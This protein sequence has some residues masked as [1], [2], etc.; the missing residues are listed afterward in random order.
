MFAHPQSKI[1]L[2]LHAVASVSHSAVNPLTESLVTSGASRGEEGEHDRNRRTRT[3]TDRWYCRPRRARVA[4]SLYHAR[5]LRG[6]VW[7]RNDSYPRGIAPSVPAKNVPNAR[8]DYFQVP[9]VRNG[10]QGRSRRSAADR[11]YFV[12]LPELR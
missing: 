1:W 8:R 5:Q 3:R 10:V 12:G 9:A 4:W 2:E 11:R 7:R 6:L